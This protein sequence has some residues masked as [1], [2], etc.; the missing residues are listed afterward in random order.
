MS[1]SLSA[2]Q[3]SLLALERKCKQQNS[4]EMFSFTT[5]IQQSKSENRKVADLK[6][7]ADC[8]HMLI[9]TPKRA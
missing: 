5:W 6:R 8:F 9:Q 1:P 7:L 4:D 3:G 2:E